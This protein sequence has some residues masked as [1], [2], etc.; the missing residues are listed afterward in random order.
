MLAVPVSMNGTSH[1]PPPAFGLPSNWKPDIARYDGRP[2]P[3]HS[4]P[5]INGDRSHS[6]HDMLRPMRRSPSPPPPPPFLPPRRMTMSMFE[7]SGTPVSNGGGS[8]PSSLPIIPGLPAKPTDALGTSATATGMSLA[9]RMSAAPA[10]P[11]PGA[12]QD[13]RARVSYHDLDSVDASEDV[14][15]QY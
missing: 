14:A 1:H 8:A 3:L 15:L 9:R 4:R 12:K 11:P 7:T 2:D 10:P 5:H 13:P 6:Y